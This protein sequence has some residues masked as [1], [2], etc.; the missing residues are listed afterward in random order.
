MNHLRNTINRFTQSGP[1]RITVFALGSS[2]FI[3][4]GLV[5]LGSGLTSALTNAQ[6][7][8]HFNS[9]TT[10]ERIG[11]SVYGVANIIGQPIIG[12]IAGTAIG[13]T[14]PISIPT[15]YYLYREAERKENDERMATLIGCGKDN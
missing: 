1:V 12:A 5:G 3:F 7:S 4:G 6:H 14:A 11:T 8:L 15:L 13:I 2:G 10:R 9:Q